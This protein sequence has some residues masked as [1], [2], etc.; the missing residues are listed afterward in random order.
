MEL[1]NYFQLTSLFSSKGPAGGVKCDCPLWVDYTEST[2]QS[3]QQFLSVSSSGLQTLY[4]TQR[5]RIYTAEL[6][7]SS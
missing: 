7:L 5:F 4:W 6:G 3:I 2:Q 1:T